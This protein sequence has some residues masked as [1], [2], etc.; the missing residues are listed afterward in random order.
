MLKHPYDR[1]DEQVVEELRENVYWV[2]FCGVPMKEIK[3]GKPLRGVGIFDDD[4]F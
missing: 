2:A 4:L 3:E 1:S